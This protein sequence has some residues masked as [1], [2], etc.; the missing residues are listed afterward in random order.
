MLL[1]S[2]FSV[3][4]FN[5]P[6]PI[7]N[8]QSPSLI[9]VFVG[10]CYVTNGIFPVP[11]RTH[12]Q[13]STIQLAAESFCKF[14]KISPSLLSSLAHFTSNWR[15]IPSSFITFFPQLPDPLLFIHLTKAARRW[16]MTS[17]SSTRQIVRF[18]I[19]WDRISNNWRRLENFHDNGID[20]AHILERS[21]TWTDYYRNRNWAGG[22]NC[23]WLLIVGVE[24]DERRMRDDKWGCESSRK[25]RAWDSGPLENRMGQVSFDRD[26]F[27][28]I[29]TCVIDWDRYRSMD[30]YRTIFVRQTFGQTN[31]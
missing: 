21:G 15:K 6:I 3:P 30:N 27:R 28:S 8:W 31:A 25:Y 5:W 16:K 19:M 9:T 29:G 11:H 4:I 2:I 18:A 13:K 10:H 24:C 17:F 12:L 20:M 14:I 1:M 26:R 22:S 23:H 7:F